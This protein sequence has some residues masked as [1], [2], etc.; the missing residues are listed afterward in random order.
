M[1]ARQAIRAPLSERLCDGVCLIF[2]L[3]TLCCQSVVAAGGGLRSLL[4]LFAIVSTLGIVRHRLAS[5]A[6]PVAATS[7]AATPVAA[8]P[9]SSA[10]GSW[11]RGLRGVALVVGLLMVAALARPQGALLWWW[12]AVVLLGVATVA[13]HRHQRVESW[14]PLR[15]RG[16]ETLL[17]TLSLACVV[18]TLISHRSDADDAF[19]V[20]LAVTAVDRPDWALLSHDTMHGVDGLPLILPVYRL[21]SYEL[22]NA[23]MSYL[24]GIPA[25]YC[26]HWLSASLAAALVP[27][28]Y[29][30]LFRLLRPHGWLAAVAVLM[31]VLIAVGESQIAA[32]GCTSSA[33]WSGPLSALAAFACAS[34]PSAKRW[35]IGSLG[36]LSSLPILLAG[37]MMKESL[38]DMTH[39]LKRDTSPLGKP[40]EQALDTVLGS[41]DV[42]RFAVFSVLVAWALCPPGLARRF[43]AT[44]PLIVLVT[45]LNPFIVCWV[46]AHLIGPSYWR[47]LWGLPIPILMTLVLISPL[48][49]NGR[50]AW[51]VGRR[52]GGRVTCLLLVT[53]FVFLIPS[54]SG[55][56]EENQVRMAP[57]ALKVP[58]IEYRWAATL[59]RNVS[60]GD[61]I[62]APE[63]VNSWV[64][65]FH[66]HAY[67]LKVRHY[68][69]RQPARD[70]LGKD[71][72]LLRDRIVAY[73]SG[74]SGAQQAEDAF[75]E[76]VAEPSIQAV[77][78]H[79]SPLNV[80]APSILRQAGFSKVSV[81]GEYE[82]W[83]RE[84]GSG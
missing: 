11:F 78:R 24:T 16:S 38:G 5:A 81:D 9:S 67:P 80:N 70:R 4:V 6:E 74:W 45:V 47:A 63:H 76:G 1:S 73:V 13:V 82:M 2:A 54:Y 31:V 56:S 41:A 51:N 12:W 72:L 50:S 43:A 75:R 49:W 32:L 61:Q 68:L 8:E 53:A 62:I 33:L 48:G 44:L 25:I 69:R 84:A 35:L 55:L 66:H 34:Q 29:A 18:L 20:N 17:W 37:W 23:A 19:Y 46:S 36:L 79:R 30:R 26:F 10:S 60:A 7:V 65:T 39:W 3:W 83:L 15:G 59:N 57:P 71:D 64:P 52:F 28:A 40:L 42:A 14:A 21:H 22:W 27:L 77:C 58:E